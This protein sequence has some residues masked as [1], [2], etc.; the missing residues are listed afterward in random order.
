MKLLNAMSDVD[1]QFKERLVAF[2]GVEDE[3][4]LKEVNEAAYD[5]ET[6]TKL[7]E[8]KLEEAQM[9]TELEAL[10][11]EETGKDGTSRAEHINWVVA[12]IKKAVGA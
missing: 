4:D 9:R 7:V 3:D 1:D 6:F 2:Y 5:F 10:I 11:K 12:E 8:P